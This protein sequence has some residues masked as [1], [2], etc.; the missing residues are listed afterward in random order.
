MKKLGLHATV[1]LAAPNE[2]RAQAASGSFQ[3]NGTFAS[4]SGIITVGTGTTDIDLAGPPAFPTGEPSGRNSRAWITIAPDWI[5]RD[6]FGADDAVQGTLKPVGQIDDAAVT[7]VISGRTQTARA[8]VELH[9][10]FCGDVRDWAAGKPIFQ[11]IFEPVGKVRAHAD[12]ALRKIMGGSRTLVALH[13]RRG[14]Y[15]QGQFW[16]APSAWYLTWLADVWP[17]LDQPVLYLATDDAAT[18]AD[19]AAYSPL[20]AAALGEPLPGCEFFT[21][22]WIMR[23]AALLATSNSTFSSTAAL[24]NRREGARF[25]RPD[26]AIE[27]LRAYEP[28]AEKIL[29]A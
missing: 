19:F 28:W 20:T 5:G 24:L 4:G 3:G 14:D 26:R 1:L 6:L 8:N 13:L 10:Y 2:A 23:H 18:V 29:L 7:E 17:Q 9:G 21:D 11:K 16:V 22:H 25:V 12:A 27:G 15:G